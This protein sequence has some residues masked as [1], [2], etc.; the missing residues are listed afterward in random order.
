MARF[1]KISADKMTVMERL[2]SSPDICKALIYSEDNFLD[3]PGLVDY[4]SL[5]YKNI[6][7]FKRIPDSAKEKTAF[8]T[9]SFNNFRPI[10]NT[11][12]SGLIYL[13]VLVH[14]DL[15]RTDYGKLR[16]DF[17]IH[18]ID[19]LMNSKEGIGIGKVEFYEM[20]EYALN[21]KYM[22]VYVAYK[23]VEFN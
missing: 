6:F 19:K 10:K 5:I 13:H 3:Q 2:I 21:D 11:F 8:I 9:M 23:L 14:Q 20:D 22:G 16:T 1:E 15:M 4:S 18:E 7:P 12:K 17:I